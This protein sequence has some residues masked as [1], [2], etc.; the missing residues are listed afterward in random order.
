MTTDASPVGP[1][2]NKHNLVHYPAS[3][4]L[5]KSRLIK[6]M[7]EMMTA[8]HMSKSTI[9]CYLS[10][11][12]DFFS[13]ANCGSPECLDGSM[14]ER[15]LT[16]IAVEKKVSA[17]YQNQH[18]NA[19]LYL[20]RNVLKKELGKIDACRAKTSQHV[21]EWLTKDEISALFKE[22]EGDWLLLAQIAYGTGARLM[23]L[24][25]LRVKDPDFGNAAIA[26]HDGKGGKDRLVPMPN[27][28]IV[29]IANRITK[30]ELIH[31]QDL[32]DGYGDVW[33]PG[34]LARKYPNASRSSRWQW[35]FPSRE[36][37]KAEDGTMRRHHLFPNGFQTE[38]R[39]AGFRAKIQKRVHPHIL[40]HS[41]A[42][43][44]LENGGNLQMLQKLLGHKSVE[45]TMIYTHCVD[46]K[47]ARSPLDQL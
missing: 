40:R 35:L 19:L 24:L 4:W 9:S 37:C 36:I 39:K 5:Q 46:L 12:A 2:S 26:I 45:T 47:S 42:T 44:F 29:P 18:F 10:A 3:L 1:T 22:L 32:K 28:L 25:R 43:H 21:P 27:K 38:L 13:W 15:Y 7:R 14:V 11:C 31:R 6:Q 33:L 23:E 20:F 34:A 30:T 16:H 17:S 8:G 41:F